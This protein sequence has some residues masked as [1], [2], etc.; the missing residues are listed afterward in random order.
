MYEVGGKTKEEESEKEACLYKYILGCRK[1][2]RGREVRDSRIAKS[3]YIYMHISRSILA[4]QHV[5][6]LQHPSGHYFPHIW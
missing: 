6:N 4:K 3:S 2:R 1:W 5:T